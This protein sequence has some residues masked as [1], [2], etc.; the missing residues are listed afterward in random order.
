MTECS[1]PFCHSH[2]DF[3]DAH[4]LARTESRRVARGGRSA[5]P[6]AL[7]PGGFV[8]LLIAV[9]CRAVQLEIGQ[10]AAFRA[11]ALRPD[12]REKPAAGGAG[13]DSG[14][15]RHGAGLR[16]GSGGRGGRVSLSGGAAAAGLA[17]TTGPQAAAERSASQCGPAGRGSAEAA[18]RA[19]R[20]APPPGR[21]VRHRASPV[22]GPGTQSPGP[23]RAD[24]GRRPAAADRSGPLGAATARRCV[25]GRSVLRGLA[26]DL[27][28][29]PRCRAGDRHRGRRTGR[30]CPGR[31]HSR[32][33]GC[34]NPA[35]RR[36]LSRHADR[37]PD[38]PDVS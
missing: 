11:E 26:R 14:P 6:P 27:R 36:T 24:R 2:S 30:P 1:I 5:P 29:R 25:V 10:G 20:A 38:P 35:A 3:A 33:G 13:K 15:R 23:R 19:R 9:W 8:L 31:R 21:P 7:V 18:A 17:G 12:R 4:R 28:A 37:S 22:A 32:G 16:S 34:G